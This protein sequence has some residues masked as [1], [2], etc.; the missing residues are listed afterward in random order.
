MIYEVKRE[1]LIINFVNFANHTKLKNKAIT[2]TFNTVSKKILI[3]DDSSSNLLLISNFL[4]SE[5]FTA[6]TCV[7]GKDA[8][9]QIAKDQPDLLMLDLM[10]PDL[11]GITI[12]ET[13]RQSSEFANLPVIIV[14]AISEGE[15]REKAE[16]L[17]V[18][19]YILKPIEFEIIYNA[20]AKTLNIK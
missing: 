8:M 16:S 4:E 12:L 5:G 20:V 15:K 2:L 7:K 14:S 3:V 19:D 10:M 1:Q 17:G 13:V 11:D 6:T 9:A 18:S